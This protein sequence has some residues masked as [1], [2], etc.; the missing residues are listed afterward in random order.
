MVRPGR[1]EQ[2]EGQEDV[3]GSQ[4]DDERW[5]P[6]LRHQQRRWPA[7]A[8]PP[9]TRPSMIAS[10]PGMP[11]VERGLRHDHRREDHDGAAG[12]VDARGQDDQGLPDG[13]C[14]H[15]RHLL[16]D[17]RQVVGRREFVVEEPEDDDADHQDDGRAQPRIRCSVVW[18]RCAGV[19]AG[20][21]TPPPRHSAGRR[22]AVPLTR[23]AFRCRLAT[24]RSGARPGHRRREAANGGGSRR[25][26]APTVRV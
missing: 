22:L 16:G 5:Q 6:H 21:G 23:A 3:Q 8:R 10:Q 17:Q 24:S 15:D 2:R 4:G 13:E 1:I 9:T 11:R 25:S 20:R 26:T 14:A 12:Q 19:Y 18:T 7:P